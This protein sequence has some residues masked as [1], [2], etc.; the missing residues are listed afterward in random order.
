MADA[1]ATVNERGRVRHGSEKQKLAGEKKKGKNEERK[2]TIH[3]CVEIRSGFPSS[4][5]LILALFSPRLASL[6]P[7]A[8]DL[9]ESI[10]NNGRPATK[11]NMHFGNFYVLFKC[12]LFFF[13]QR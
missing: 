8:I 10:R 5:S 13:F 6:P 12:F 2:N 1:T 7:F 4:P 11:S 9:G 3:R